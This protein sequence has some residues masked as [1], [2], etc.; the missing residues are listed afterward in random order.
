MKFARRTDWPAEQ[1][2]LALRLKQLRREQAQ[3]LDLT[4]SNPTRCGFVYDDVAIRGALSQAAVM[5][6][7]PDPRG[8]PSAREAVCRYYEE[9]GTPIPADR[10]FL[11]ASTSE[12]YT[13]CFRLLCEPGDEIL[14]PK[15]SYPLFDYLADLTDVKLV[16]YQLIYDNGWQ[17]DLGAL[18]GLISARTKAILTVAPNNPTGQLLTTKERDAL[19]RLA[20]MNGLALICD[21]VF[22]DYVWEGGKRPLAQTI[23]SRCLCLTLAISGLSKISA[24]PQMKLGWVTIRGPVGPD[25]ATAAR[26]EVM[27]DT[28][29]SVSTPIQA[30]ASTLIEQRRLLQ[31]QVL[32]RILQNLDF[33]DAKLSGRTPVSRLQADGGWYATLR[34]P[35]SLADEE[36]AVYLLETAGVHVHPGSLFGFESEGYLVISLIQRHEEFREAV[37][38]LVEAVV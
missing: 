24:L 10:V 27:A 18:R 25:A 33:L 35:A 4:E 38:R 3:I 2:R 9:R 30:A 12:A 11:T 17:I 22:L 5:S 34:T 6:Y 1:T 37:G 21:E 15:P 14:V 8:I 13:Y 29:L 36:W 26:F 32:E 16:P 23:D 28:Y 19:I 31:P 7:D 20:L